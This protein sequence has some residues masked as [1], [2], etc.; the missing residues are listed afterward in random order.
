[1][2]GLNKELFFEFWE[3]C[4]KMNYCIIV[5]GKRDK[6]VLKKVGFRNLLAINGKSLKEIAKQIKGEVV[7]LTDF[8]KEGKE[9]ARK[10][11]KYLVK[12]GIR[13]NDRLRKKFAESCRIRKIEEFKRYLKEVLPL[14][15]F[16]KSV[17]F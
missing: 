16:Y 1:L 6:S 2:R 13:V 11:K 14:L 8:D 7:I 10:L 9:K 12:L 17:R 5:E 3:E 15:K 4:N